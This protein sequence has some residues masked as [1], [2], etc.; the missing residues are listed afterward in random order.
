MTVYAEEIGIQFRRKMPNPNRPCRQ[1]TRTRNIRNSKTLRCCGLHAARK[2]SLLCESNE[3]E[4]GRTN[5]SCRNLMNF[6][7]VN[8]R[9]PCIRLQHVREL[10][11]ISARACR[12]HSLANGLLFC[13]LF[14]ECDDTLLLKKATCSKSDHLVMSGNVCLG[15]SQLKP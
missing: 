5:D 8:G 11:D 10:H 13:V 4:V 9:K 6:F 3:L 14:W 12:G 15:K 7:V 1:K 2:D